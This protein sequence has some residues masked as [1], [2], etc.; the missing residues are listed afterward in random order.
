VD[1]AHTIAEVLNLAA[2]ALIF[3]GA[4][5]MLRLGSDTRTSVHA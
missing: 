3:V 4:V 1:R 5:G 2:F